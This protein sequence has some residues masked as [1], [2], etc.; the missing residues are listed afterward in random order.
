MAKFEV[1]IAHTKTKANAS[2]LLDQLVPRL[3]ETYRGNVSNAQYHWSGSTLHFSFSARGVNI[4]GIATV[5]ER[6]VTISGDLPFFLGGFREAV[7]D[8]LKEVAPRL[9]AEHLPWEPL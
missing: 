1:S 9:L 8:K 2:L 5:T 4:S 3:A 6:Q 7:E